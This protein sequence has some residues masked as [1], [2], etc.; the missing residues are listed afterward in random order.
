M[1][2]KLVMNTQ[3]I[4]YYLQE[5]KMSKQGFAKKCEISLK[6]L[7]DIY[8]QHCADV[9][10]IL[11]IIKVLNIRSDTFLFMDRSYPK[12]VYVI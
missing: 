3:Y 9:F 12:K 11:K 7:E 10:Q 4:D 2:K 5:H 8:N 1:E 6:F